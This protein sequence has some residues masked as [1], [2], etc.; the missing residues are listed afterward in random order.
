MELALK[1]HSD[2]REHD[3]NRLEY[4]VTELLAFARNGE[5]T[6]W[7]QMLDSEKV[8]EAC[9]KQGTLVN[10][11]GRCPVLRQARNTS[12]SWTSY[13]YHQMCWIKIWWSQSVLCLERLVVSKH[14]CVRSTATQYTVHCTAHRLNL[15]LHSLFNSKKV[16]FIF[17][18]KEEGQNTEL[19]WCN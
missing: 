12:D 2:T 1:K 18:Q 16:K 19:A 13:S 15:G 11:V 7:Q 9:V 17:F 3:D 8:N 4:V 5:L 6:C 14:R 10:N